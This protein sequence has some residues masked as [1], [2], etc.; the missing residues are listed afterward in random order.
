M[1]WSGAGLEAYMKDKM[2]Q[3]TNKELNQF[4]KEVFNETHSKDNY[5]HKHDKLKWGKIRIDG[6]MTWLRCSGCSL[7][8]ALEKEA[9]AVSHIC[10]KKGL[11]A[12]IE[13]Q[14]KRLEDIK[15]ELEEARKEMSNSLSHKDKPSSAP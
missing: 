9:Y 1:S 10:Y 7:D 5:C 11:K 13:R 4:A 8:E 6:V 3:E 14:K 15:K 12:E 2:K